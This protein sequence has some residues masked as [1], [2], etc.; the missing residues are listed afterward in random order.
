MRRELYIVFML[1][2][3]LQGCDFFYS[4]VDYKGKEADMRLCVVSRELPPESADD[5]FR[6]DVLHSMFFLSDEDYVLPV[7]KDAKV[8]VQV[9][10]LPAVP[11]VYT[12]DRDT[13]M[14]MDGTG[15]V[16]LRILEGGYMTPLAFAAKDT[17]RLHVEH[18][19]YGTADAVQVCPVKQPFTLS[20]DS[21]SEYGE[22]W[23]H[24]HVPA[25]TGDMN[26]VLTIQA[27]IM[28]DEY[29][30]EGMSMFAY[31]RD[32]AFAY[33]DNY[34]TPSGYYAG[35]QLHMQPALT[36]RDIALVFYPGVG[37][38]ADIYDDT[39]DTILNISA[40]MLA[41]TREDYMYKST[42]YAALGR[43]MY[44][45]ELISERRQSSNPADDYFDI[46][47]EELFYMI[48][49]NFD[50]LGNAES[51][52]VYGNL[53]GSNKQNIQPFGCFSLVNTTEQHIEYSLK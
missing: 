21:V 46:N 48:S 28:T 44:V 7:L 33:Y 50:V 49:E 8:S 13:V 42:M 39:T 24:M 30:E 3:L 53:S 31:S 15:N 22:L 12:S 25:Y 19:A 51:Y 37:Y 5:L 14:T 6:V 18:P 45:N 40:Y 16:Y 20:I 36:D 17:V 11:A 4:T 29:D 32:E 52:Q 38:M 26:G 2:L 9:N 27:A 35:Y 43:S 34:Q 10:S 41:R 23:C 1:A 47:M